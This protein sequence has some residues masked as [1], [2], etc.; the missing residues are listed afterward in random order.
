MEETKWKGRKA[1]NIGEGF[2]LFYHG[3]DAK[4]NGIGVILKEECSKSVVEVKRVSNKVMNMKLEV[5]GVIIYVIS[6]FSTQ[7]GCEMKEMEKFSCEL[8]EVVE[9]EP[10][11]ER[12]VIGADLNELRGPCSRSA[13]LDITASLQVLVDY[14]LSILNKLCLRLL[15]LPPPYRITGY[16]ESLG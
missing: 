7:V 15:R 1:R 8:D 16:L 4:R 3:V 2:K 12:M 5:E 11:S 10:R 13:P 9:N 14:L 6:P